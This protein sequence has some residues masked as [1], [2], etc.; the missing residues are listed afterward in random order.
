MLSACASGGTPHLMN[1]RSATDGP[2]EFAI[3]PPK[4]LEMPKDL[5]ALPAPEPGGANLSDRN[6]EADAIAALGGKV[7]K[8]AGGIAAADQGLVAYADRKGL[9]AD[10][11]SLL[12]AEDLDWRK[13]HDGRLLERVF[14]VSVYYRAYRDFAL[15]QFQALQFWR[16]QGV[17]TP[18]APPP[19]NGER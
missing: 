3:L 4:A 9:T 10:I 19:Q 18:S 13:H 8:P 6:P 12:A 15:D 1:L 17:A 14:A 11:R 5:T 16:A 7:A 2:D